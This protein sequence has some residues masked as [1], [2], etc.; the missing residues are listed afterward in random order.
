MSG[1]RQEGVDVIYFRDGAACVVS[2]KTVIS[3]DAIKTRGNLTEETLVGLR[4]QQVRR[5]L[6]NLEIGEQR[7]DENSADRLH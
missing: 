6:R 1:G 5:G 2:W 4:E 7:G 3:S